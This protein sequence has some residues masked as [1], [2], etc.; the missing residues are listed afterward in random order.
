MFVH[1]VTSLLRRTLL[2][3]RGCTTRF[4]LWSDSFP[5]LPHGTIA[6]RFFHRLLDRSNYAHRLR[7]E[8]L[9]LTKSLCVDTGGDWRNWR[10]YESPDCEL[11]GNGSPILKLL[12]N[13]PAQSHL[14]CPLCAVLTF[15]KYGGRTGLQTQK[16]LKEQT[17]SPSKRCC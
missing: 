10:A 2:C 16:S 6:Q 7:A 15:V 14:C 4:L 5:T 13:L 3:C 11:L 1:S 17:V 9:G 12:E 8:S